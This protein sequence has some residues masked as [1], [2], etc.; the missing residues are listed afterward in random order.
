MS[1]SCEMYVGYT[2]NIKEDLTNDDFEKYEKFTRNYPEYA[3]RS[4]SEKVNKVILIDDGMNGLYARL[5]FVELHVKECWIEG[6]D[7]YILNNNQIPEA[8]LNALKLAYQR[9]C[10]KELD[11]NQI[12]YSLWYHFS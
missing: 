8:V 4:N 6:N 10:H 3:E 2:I 11:I 9:L 7:Y 5:I 1:V 12:E